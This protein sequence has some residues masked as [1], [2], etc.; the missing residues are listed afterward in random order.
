MHPEKLPKVSIITVNFNQAAVTCQLLDT[1]RKVSYSNVEV[2]VVDNGSTEPAGHIA[3]SYP[4]VHF[5]RSEK[6]LGF[7]GGNNLA[8][9]QATGDYLMLINNDTEAPQDFLQPL[10]E[11]FSQYPDAG[12]VSPRLLFFMKTI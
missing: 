2:W 12:I 7:A 8:L 9:T 6:N 5:I 4:E 3:Q 10:L 11:T 1:L